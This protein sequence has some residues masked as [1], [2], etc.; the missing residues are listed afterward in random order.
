[1]LK[2]SALMKTA[3]NDIHH[4]FD[5]GGVILNIDN[6]DDLKEHIMK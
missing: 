3:N 4:K 6:F 5:V 2:V 1:M